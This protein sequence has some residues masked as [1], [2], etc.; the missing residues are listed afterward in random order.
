MSATELL[1]LVLGV[2]ALAVVGV[3]IGEHAY[4]RRRGRR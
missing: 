3:A 1:L 4:R 2:A